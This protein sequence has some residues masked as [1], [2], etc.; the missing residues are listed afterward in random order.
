MTIPGKPRANRCGGTAARGHDDT[1]QITLWR[2]EFGSRYAER[3][4]P[5]PEALAMVTCTWARILQPH[6]SR[7]PLC[8][9]EIGH[10]FGLNL[11]ALL[12]PLEA[13][14]YAAEPNAAAHEKTL[15][16]FRETHRVA[17][18]FVGRVEYSSPRPEA[19]PNHSHEGQV[20]KR[21]FGSFWLFE[22]RSW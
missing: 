2:S 6:D 22:R 10:T 21:D 14:L 1:K 13:K 12:R 9:L 8:D 18:P 20:F 7:L 19:I 5:T 17:S 15:A 3:N 4:E 11:R 16:S